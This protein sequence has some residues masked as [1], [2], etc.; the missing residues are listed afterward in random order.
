MV[1]M[2]PINTV[3]KN[4][5]GACF[6]GDGDHPFLNVHSFLAYRHAQ[7]WSVEKITRSLGKGIIE[8]RE[9]LDPR[10]LALAC[11]GVANSRGITPNMRSIFSCGGNCK[12]CVT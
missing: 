5:D 11:A 12:L 10:V 9:T 1:M 6:L 4:P 3:R 2:A 8:E 7:V